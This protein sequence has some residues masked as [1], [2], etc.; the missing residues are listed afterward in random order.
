MMEH[1][2]QIPTA[3][4][5]RFTT[6]LWCLGCKAFGI[7]IELSPR[8]EGGQA[9]SCLCASVGL[10]H[11]VRALAVSAPCWVDARLHRRGR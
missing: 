1:W 8:V 11:I 2:H 5:I 10:L 9:L 6:F 7:G 3:S 4:D